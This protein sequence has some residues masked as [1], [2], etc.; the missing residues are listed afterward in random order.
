[1]AIRTISQTANG[2][3]FKC[4]KCEAF[5]IEY[6][7]LNFNFNEHQLKHFIKCIEEID[8]EKWERV[9]QTS[10]Y[11]RKIIIPIGHHSFNVL[12]NNKELQELKTLLKTEIKKVS[13]LQVVNTKNL[14]F[15]TNLN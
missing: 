4:E 8:G 10:S 5:H 3:I 2:K 14:T 6:K 15:K 9:N 1:M 13:Y 11:K 7:N 12:L